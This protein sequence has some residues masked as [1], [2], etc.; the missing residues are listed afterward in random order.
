MGFIAFLSMLAVVVMYVWEQRSKE[1][2]SEWAAIECDKWVS[3]IALPGRRTLIAMG[4]SGL[5][6]ATF[7]GYSGDAT[8][9][10]ERSWGA[11]AFLFVAPILG[12]WGI[13]IALL[14]V[15]RRFDVRIPQL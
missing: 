7:L 6:W 15:V 8:V 12:G 9:E 1:D 4:V 14:S 10:V 2:Q 11:I 13:G 3:P 5:L